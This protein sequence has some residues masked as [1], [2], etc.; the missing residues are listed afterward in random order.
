MLIKASLEALAHDPYFGVRLGPQPRGPGREAGF[1]KD[2][3][4]HTLI[5]GLPVLLVW[6]VEEAHKFADLKRGCGKG[7]RLVVCVRSRCL[8]LCPWRFRCQ[9]LANFLD[10]LSAI[11]V[12]RVCSVLCCL[13][14]QMFVAATLGVRASTHL[15]LRAKPDMRGRPRGVIDVASVVGLMACL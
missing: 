7:G 9:V 5:G 8:L 15:G 4:G 6:E 12:S 3:T 13:A 2:T 11:E 14:L 10:L 1:R